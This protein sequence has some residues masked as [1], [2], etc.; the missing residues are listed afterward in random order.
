MTPIPSVCQH[1]CGLT[2]VLTK[3]KRRQDPNLA[4]VQKAHTTGSERPSVSNSPRR[5]LSSRNAD[6][7]SGRCLWKETRLSGKGGDPATPGREPSAARVALYYLQVVEDVAADKRRARA[8][9]RGQRDKTLDCTS[10]W[11]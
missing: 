5:L 7:V 3:L 8:S 10:S 2:T 9:P 4:G 1:G 6:G 11:T